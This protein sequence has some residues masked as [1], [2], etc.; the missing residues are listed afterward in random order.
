M[1]GQA[2]WI[3]PWPG[4]VFITGFVS[5]VLAQAT[6]PGCKTTSENPLMLCYLLKNPPKIEAHD[7]TP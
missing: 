6:A 5:S 7:H 1:S 2:R 3:V 4:A